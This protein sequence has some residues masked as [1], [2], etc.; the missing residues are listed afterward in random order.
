GVATRSIAAEQGAKLG[1]ALTFDY[2]PHEQVVFAKIKPHFINL[3]NDGKLST[4]GRYQSD[5][6]DVDDVFR[7]VSE[8]SA[9][10]RGTPRLLLYAHGGLNDEKASAARIASL[11]PYFLANEIYPIH[12]MWE[13]GLW[14]AIKGIVQDA[15]R[16]QRFG[17]LWDRA[18]ERFLDLLDE[19]IELATRKLGLLIWGQMKQNAELAS[20]Q[21]G[22]ADIVAGKIANYIANDGKLELHLVGHSAGSIFLGRLIPEIERWGLKVK[23]LTLYAPACDTKLFEDNVQHYIGRGHRRCIERLTVFNLTD[24][25]E[26]ED[27]VAKV[28]HK[29]LLYLVSEAFEAKK[30]EMLL[31]ME[32]HLPANTAAVASLGTRTRRG[33]TVI[34]SRGGRNVKLVSSSTSHGGFDNDTDTLNSTLRIIRG[35]NELVKSFPQR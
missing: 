25:A 29:S 21:G 28:Y 19:A 12:F 8:E 14:D 31:G 3:G 5:E 13:T 33:S 10:W 17:G 11:R 9:S 34:H 35:S 18:K 15:D 20:Q 22:G 7:H 6:R 30:H 16:D 23:T 2:L 32:K 1:K 4:S 26:R 27:H 24:D